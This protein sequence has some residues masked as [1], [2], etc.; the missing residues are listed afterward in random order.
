MNLERGQV[1]SG[2]HCDFCHKVG[3]VYLAPSNAQVY[4]NSAGV[5]SMRLLRP[6]EG[7]QI[8]IGPYPDIHDPDTYNPVFHQSD[9]CAPCHQFSFW[10]TQI[11]NSYGEWLESSYAEDGVTCQDCHMA[12]TGDQYFALP[13]AGGLQH[14]PENIPSHQQLGLKDKAFMQSTLD[15]AISHEITNGDLDLTV[16]L[17]NVAAGHHV[18]TDHPG[19]HIILVVRA[20]DSQGTAI[21]CSQCP[22]I[23]PWAGNFAGEAGVVYAKV[24]RDAKTGAFPVVNYW[25]QTLIHSDTRI[26][27]DERRDEH[28]YFRAADDPITIEI[29]VIFRRMFQPQADVYAWDLT[30]IILAEETITILP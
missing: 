14:S 29:Q 28:F 2:I 30:E 7:E 18:P 22:Q 9:F 27:A 10:G 23:P 3:G 15:L 16:S 19:R 21:A 5:I 13:E 4:T 1:T 26:A 25:N 24:L 17:T 6:P 8:F 20:Y 11:Y 12:P